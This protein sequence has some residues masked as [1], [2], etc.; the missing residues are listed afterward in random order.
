MI[1]AKS[2]FIFIVRAPLAVAFPLFGPEGERPWAGRDWDPQFF[3][4][5]PARDMEGAVFRIRR[6]HREAI[7]VNTIFD[8][9]AG[10]AAYVSIIDKK[11][12]TRIDV[13]LRQIDPQ[14]TSVRVM[15]E[16]TA[17]D[18]SAEDE[19]EEMARTDPQMG[20]EWEKSI[21]DYL[22]RG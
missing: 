15:Y 21:S 3:Y 19:V 2:E 7:W 12:A 11:I 4:P 18:S 22:A 17:L 9:Q 20:R 8:I 14:T 13:Q 1:R 10:H 16:R 5:T 6:G